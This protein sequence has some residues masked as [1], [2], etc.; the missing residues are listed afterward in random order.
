MVFIFF[1]FSR[2]VFWYY[3]IGLVKCGI[4]DTGTKSHSGKS[5]PL[6]KDFLVFKTGFTAGFHWAMTANH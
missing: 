1:G 2:S 6:A 5:A 3:H 4:G